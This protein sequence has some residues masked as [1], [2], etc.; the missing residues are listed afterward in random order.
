MRMINRRGGH[1]NTASNT[2]LCLLPGCPADD[3]RWRYSILVG[4]SH[5]SQKLLAAISRS[6]SNQA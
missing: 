2:G 1:C 3:G 6:I 4:M 5:D